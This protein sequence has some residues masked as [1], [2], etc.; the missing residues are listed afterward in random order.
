MV[1]LEIPKGVTVIGG[2][3]FKNC[4][5]LQTVTLSSNLERIGEAVF[6]GCTSC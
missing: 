4:I 3:T 6:Y 1:T 2:Y 5:S